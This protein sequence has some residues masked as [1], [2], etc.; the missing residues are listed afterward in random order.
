LRLPEH[1]SYSVNDAISSFKLLISLFSTNENIIINKS[2]KKIFSDL[3]F[4]L[5]NPILLKKCSEVDC[6]N[7]GDSE[8][9]FRLSFDLI[10]KLPKFMV[11]NME[12]FYFTLKNKFGVN[13]QYLRCISGRM[14]RILRKYPDLREIRIVVDSNQLSKGRSYEKIEEDLQNLFHGNHVADRYLVEMF[15]VKEMK[16]KLKMKK[17]KTRKLDDAIFLLQGGLFVNEVSI[18]QT[19]I[20]YI[21]DDIIESFPQEVRDF[22]QINSNNNTNSD[23]INNVCI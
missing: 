3:G 2:N 16:K 12:D 22:L 23:L 18:V 10:P 19:K 1:P 17:S 14:K 15:E 20:S 13:L 8:S 21:P 5:E 6:L 7:E 9:E 11:S 4:S